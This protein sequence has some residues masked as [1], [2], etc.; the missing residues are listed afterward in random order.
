MALGILC[1]NRMR[2]TLNYLLLLLTSC[3]LIGCGGAS[4]AASRGDKLFNNASPEIKA[5]WKTASGA[6]RSNDYA[7][8]L[9]TLGKLGA[10]T[11]LTPEQ[12]KCITDLSKS[13]S[14][15]M[16]DAANK[17]DAKAK[18]ALEDLRKISGH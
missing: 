13:V 14:D 15:Q 1:F 4:S 6:V 12:Q 8:A 18:Q 16:Y 3:V 2:T 5:D 7:M 11:D 17:G 10:R 9:A